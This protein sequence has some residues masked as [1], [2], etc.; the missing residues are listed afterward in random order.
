MSKVRYF[1]ESFNIPECTNIDFLVGLGCVIHHG[2]EILSV[3]GNG[4]E[5]IHCLTHVFGPDK[6]GEIT[7]ISYKNPKVTIEFEVLEK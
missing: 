1:K 3:T 7:N 6:F 2:S 4:L 5:T